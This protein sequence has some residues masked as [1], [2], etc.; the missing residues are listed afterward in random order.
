MGDAAH[1]IHPLAGQGLNLGLAD[2]RA[3]AHTIGYAVQHGQDLGDI[4]TLERYNAERWG[5]NAK[6]AGAC[7]LLGKAYGV[8]GGLAGAVRGWGMGVLDQGWVPGLKGWVMR[9]AEG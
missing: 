6:V 7:D 8:Q 5:A 2:A 4:L 1:T 9:Q 3:L